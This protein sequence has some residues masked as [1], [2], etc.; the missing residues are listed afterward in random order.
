MKKIILLLLLIGSF[1]FVMYFK[2]NIYQFILENYIFKKEIEI[3]PANDY[4][5]KYPFAYIHSTDQF[6]IEKK[7]DFLQ[8]FYTVLNKGWDEFSFYCDTKYKTCQDDVKTMIQDHKLL[9]SINNFVNPFN[10]YKQIAINMS[11]YGKITI[12]IHKLYNSNEI[13]QLNHK[14]D[15]IY[16]SIITDDM[17]T[18]DKIKA[19]HDYII[20]T[21]HY[22]KENVDIV[23]NSNI[24]TLK[25]NSHKAIGPLFEGI[26]LCG[27]YTD[28]MALFLN[29]MNIPN[30]KISSEHHVWNLVYLDQTWYH[31]DLTWDDPVT[32]TEEQLLLYEFFLIDTEQLEKKNTGQHQ[33]PKDI[34]IE[35]Q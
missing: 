25:T 28:A 2:E 26:A 16:A 4:E 12:Y 7:E 19:V 31:L 35:A 17:S 8:I 23:T 6:L 34:Y 27:G 24:S 11:E 3:L 33:Y 5:V 29:K 9:S 18:R 32:N 22:D 13:E 30:Y 14:V 20:Q 1:A 15:Q 10:S 21:T